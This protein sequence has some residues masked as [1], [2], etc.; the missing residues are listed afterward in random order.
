MIQLLEVLNYEAVKG[1]PSLPNYALNG[2]NN[3]T[4][5]LYLQ[6]LN[7]CCP[8]NS[9]NKVDIKVQKES[10]IPGR[11]KLTAQINRLNKKHIYPSTI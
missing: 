4:P 6:N 5:F 1:K 8:F 10:R 3:D 9:T 11:R 7:R 2:R